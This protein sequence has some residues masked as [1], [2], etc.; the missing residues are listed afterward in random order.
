MSTLAHLFYHTMPNIV[1]YLLTGNCTVSTHNNSLCFA[2]FKIL[3]TTTYFFT[4]YSLPWRRY[5]HTS[6]SQPFS[7]ITELQALIR[8]FSTTY[9]HTTISANFKLIITFSRQTKRLS[10]GICNITQNR[11]Y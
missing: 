10:N 5:E 4:V 2:I 9:K 1:I 6:I 11:C 8:Y 3:N 7:I